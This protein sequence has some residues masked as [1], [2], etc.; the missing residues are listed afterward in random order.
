M[1]HIA[2]HFLQLGFS[3]STATHRVNTQ[4][5]EY[6]RAVVALARRESERNSFDKT[7]LTS[8][9]VATCSRNA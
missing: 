9:M 6:I 7:K 8:D 1:F 2:L 3:H 4:C 5:I